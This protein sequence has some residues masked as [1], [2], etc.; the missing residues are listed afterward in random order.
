MPSGSGDDALSAALEAL[1][2]RFSRVIAAV[3]LRHGLEA[4]DMDELFQHVR[5]RLWQA[6]P[7]P[8]VMR[9][10][11]ATYVYRTAVSVALDHMRARRARSKFV[12]LEQLDD[13]TTQVAAATTLDTL[14]SHD[15]AAKVE[16]A[17][18]TLPHNRRILVRMY[19]AGYERGADH[20]NRRL[21]DHSHWYR[22]INREDDY[23][24]SESARLLSA[25]KAS[26]KAKRDTAFCSAPPFGLKPFRLSTFRPFHPGRPEQPACLPSSRPPELRW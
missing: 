1:V 6:R 11:P 10:M 4:S 12:P 13:D 24:G 22:G 15:L 8:A 20:T 18:G 17:L 26:C 21:H 2:D 23:G 16:A 19:L 3:G 5:L 25:L 9:E 7:D 14:A